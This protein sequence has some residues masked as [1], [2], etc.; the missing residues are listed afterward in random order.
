MSTAH[1]FV[2]INYGFA[3]KCCSAC[4]MFFFIPNNIEQACV[5]KGRNWWCP[6]CGHHWRYGDTTKAKL[7]KQLEREKKRT[8]WAT[9]RADNN[10]A[11]AEREK[12]KKAAYKGLLTKTKKRIS[13]GVCPCCNRSFHNL[14]KHMKS[15]HPNYGREDKADE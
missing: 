4:G 10:A 2:D 6:G 9:I 5:D 7:E 1:Q 12:R 8:E 13:G 14:A 15:K 11:W 3:T